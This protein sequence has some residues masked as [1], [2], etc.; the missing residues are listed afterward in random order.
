MTRTGDVR[1]KFEVFRAMI[2]YI[3]TFPEREH[4]PKE[5][6][7]L[8]ARLLQRDPAARALVDTLKAEH[9]KGAQL[10]RDL[11]R[12]LSE[13]ELIWPHGTEEFNAAAKAYA[14]FHWNHMRT[15]ENELLPRAERAL[16]EQDWREMETAFRTNNEPLADLKHTD[17]KALFQRILHLAPAPVGLGDR[18]KQASASSG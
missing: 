8:F 2:Y 11:E 14:Q 18:W 7:Y 3:D 17:F 16:T 6:D 12:A 5:D 15:E 1:P 4:H 13:L 10:V 9:V